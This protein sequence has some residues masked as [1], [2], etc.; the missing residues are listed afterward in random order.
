MQENIELKISVDDSNLER[1][2]TEHARKLD[3]LQDS[4][5]DVGQEGTQAMSQLSSAMSKTAVTADALRKRMEENQAQTERLQKVIVF[6]QKALLNL[7]KRY[8]SYG[9]RASKE[10]KRVKR[11]MDQ[12]RDSLKEARAQARILSQE[13][14][15]SKAQI[16]NLEAGGDRIRLASHQVQ[17]L[18]FQF[19]D[20]AV[21]IGS[22]QGIFR[23]LLQQG[24]QIVEAI[25]G[26]RKA[27]RFFS[28]Q[29]SFAFKSVMTLRGGMMLLIGSTVG[30]IAL[31]LLIFLGKSQKAMDALSDTFAYVSGVVNQLV[32]N[33]FTL[34]ESIIGLVKGE[35]TL[36]DVGTAVAS[37]GDGLAEAGS[38]AKELN[39]EM[40]NLEHIEKSL[41]VA[42]AQNEKRLV[43]L[44]NI[45]DDQSKSFRER[46][47]AQQALDKERTQSLQQDLTLAR[48]R[49]EM[50]NTE[51]ARTAQ[52]RE[53]AK[54]IIADTD[55]QREAK[56]KVAEIEA[57]LLQ[58]SFDAEKAER[59]LRKERQEAYKERQ[60]ALEDLRQ[61]AQD[62]RDELQKAEDSELKGIDKVRAE[63]A[64]AIV[65]L[66]RQEAELR[67]LYKE[68]GVQ[69]DLEEEFAQ[70]RVIINDRASK[71]IRSILSQEAAAAR[72]AAEERA[73]AEK[74]LAEERLE[75]ELSSLDTREEILLNRVELMERRR[76]QT[77]EDFAVEV[78]RRKL[79]IQIAALQQRARLLAQQYGPNSPE[80]I[81]ANQQVQLLQQEY[82]RAGQISTAPFDRIKQKLLDALSITEEDANFLLDSLGSAV[83]AI[84]DMIGAELDFQIARQDAIIDKSKKNIDDLQSELDAALEAQAAGYANNAALLQQ[85]LELEQQALE[86]AEER[87]A[88]LQEKATKR[89][90]RQNQ[91]QAAS[92]YALM[93]IRLLSSETATKGVVGIGIALGGIALIAK[94]IAEQKK[95]AA[96]LAAPGFKDGTPFVEGP[97]DSRSDS[98]PAW[99][100]R[101]ERVITAKDNAEI[102]GRA[103]TP[104]ELVKYVKIG[105]AIE[106]DVGSFALPLAKGQEAHRRAQDALQGREYKAMMAAYNRASA[107]AADR[108]VRAVESQPLVIPVGD[109]T[110]VRVGKNKWKVYTQK[111]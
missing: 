60:K 23:P 31:P 65:D 28:Q 20:L 59:A 38:E 80:V 52:Q 46:A 83:S 44:K 92:E 8:K 58:Q 79:N 62:F 27:L 24:P 43:K 4:F 56:I 111:D 98:I 90:A 94:I 7:E 63:R 3:S 78:E 42:R 36:R 99:L 86:A 13:Q 97:G 87:R 91:I 47:A 41:E 96:E 10:A 81:L 70:M 85:R 50:A 34:G 101:G 82:E 39:Q 108:I 68:R 11:S 48:T 49:L 17:N 32:N 100:S 64:A 57:A 6:K 104:T 109:S 30:L 95:V 21:Q 51:A 103:L 22:G 1:A 35:K 89:Q 61:K 102:G 75:S 84:T 18:R 110:R 37:L 16:K 72:K 26:P 9:D 77:E 54:G 15:I 53:N 74:E 12:V 5:D 19:T 25:G 71:E 73:Q 106:A 93:V 40:R 55:E 33:F 88:Q 2:L 66:E 14:V 105:K 67:A 69:F 76:G 107:E 45:A 29:A